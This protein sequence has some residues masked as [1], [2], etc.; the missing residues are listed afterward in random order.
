MA[1]AHARVI[2][3]ELP[4][5]APLPGAVLFAFDDGAFPFQ[6]GVRVHLSQGQNPRIV[7]P[8]G[9]EGDPDE[10]LLYY[11]SIVRVG[12]TLHCWYN[13]NFGPLQ[14]KIGYEREKCVL[15]YATSKDG[16][17][18]QKPDLGLVEFNGSKHNNIVR[19]DEPTLWSTAAVVHDPDDPDPKRRFKVAY[20][21]YYDGWPHFCVAWSE[22]GLSWTRSPSNPRGTFL[23]AA[24]VVK[25]RGLY[26]VCGQSGSSNNAVPTR[27]L[28]SF[29]SADFEHW[30]PCG[31]MGLDRGPAVLAPAEAAN[32]NQW[33]EVHL[34][35]GLWNRGNVILGVYGMWHG[36][37]PTGDRALASID[38]GLV[39]SHDAMHYKEPL[40]GFR[41][42]P[43]REQPERP[44]GV[45]P[46]LEQGQGMVNLGDQTLFWYGLWRGTEGSGIR[47]VT[48][49]RDR[50]GALRPFCGR[51]ARRISGPT[52]R[53]RRSRPRSRRGADRCGCA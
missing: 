38:L 14:N 1:S 47:L 24:G 41:L 28:V 23:E 26:Y 16:V 13:G 29:A 27:K 33:E 9:K 22:D 3:P 17:T 7:L 50:M 32:W 42:V 51:S 30:S 20:E 34:G 48:W 46:S 5:A 31:V 4:S 12:D 19:L 18:W 36:H 39:V 8:H 35:A 2:L 11:G 21:A 45:W 6:D 10:V 49:P 40:P 25:H 53:R 15:C 43:A 37:G 44:L 52:R